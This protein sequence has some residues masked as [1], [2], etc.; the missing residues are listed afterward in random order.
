MVALHKYKIINQLSKIKLINQLQKKFKNEKFI[1]KYIKP[2]EIINEEKEELNVNEIKKERRKLPTGQATEYLN[3]F[4]LHDY[5]GN[6]IPEHLRMIY[7]PG[8]GLAC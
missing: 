6:I 1:F 7:I 2:K 3:K 5:K 4:I 8:K